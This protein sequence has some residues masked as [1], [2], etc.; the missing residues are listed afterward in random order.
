MLTVAVPALVDV[1]AFCSHFA[2]PIWTLAGEG[3]FCIETLL[4]WLAVVTVL[5]TLIHIH[6]AVSLGLKTQRAGVE[7]LAGRVLQAGVDLVGGFR[8]RDDR[9]RARKAQVAP[10]VVKA[11]HLSLT[12]LWD[13][14]TFIYIFAVLSLWIPVISICTFRVSVS[15]CGWL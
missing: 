3:A 1:N 5:F 14:L 8:G 13:C 2:I 10:I 12:G 11:L 6:A 4:T 15:F 7:W 9:G